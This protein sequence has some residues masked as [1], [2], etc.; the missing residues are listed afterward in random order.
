MSYILEAL[1]KSEQTRLHGAG[2]MR[3]SLL[4]AS[5]AE[6]VPRRGR[7]YALLAGL[8]LLNALVL[9]PR[10]APPPRDEATMTRTDGATK[11]IGRPAGTALPGK[12]AAVSQRP[13]RAV[14]AVPP[15]HPSLPGVPAPAAP[16]VAA[17]EAALPAEG[18]APAAP[19]PRPESAGAGEMPPDL[20]KQLPPLA[21]AGYIRD[22][23]AHDMVIVNDKLLRAGDEVE[24]GLRLEQILGD[25]LVFNYKGFRFKR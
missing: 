1:Q 11:P 22:A 4:P 25:G 16:P 5:G 3:Y 9:Y 14:A 21:V 12:P 20:M 8:V 18:A 15:A 23:G 2:A 13:V 7:Y 24:P 19:L 10:R 17:A 6:A